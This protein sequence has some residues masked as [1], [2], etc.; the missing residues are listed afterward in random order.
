MNVVALKE[1][2]HQLIDKSSDELKLEQLLYAFETNDA[3]VLNSEQIEE[4]DKRILSHNLG[5]TT[6][7]S[8]SEMLEFVRAKK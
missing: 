3:T 2:L 4:L 7:Y 5:K 6:Y 1:K 8:H